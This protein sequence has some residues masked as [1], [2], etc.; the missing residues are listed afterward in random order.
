[1][2]KLRYTPHPGNTFPRTDDPR[3][4]LIDNHIYDVF[5]ESQTTVKLVGI[6][7]SFP[8]YVFTKITVSDLN[9]IE[10]SIVDRERNAVALLKRWRDK[11]LGKV[12]GGLFVTLLED[13][14][15]CLNTIFAEYGA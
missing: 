1:M 5:S 3:T 12:M 14:E 8:K 2:N 11:E 10:I 9:S 15:T 6:K 4:V 7:G 13:T